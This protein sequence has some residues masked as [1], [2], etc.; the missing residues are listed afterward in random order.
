MIRDAGPIHDAPPAGPIVG[1]R[2][3]IGSFLIHLALLTTLVSYDAWLQSRQLAHAGAGGANG[4]VATTEDYAAAPSGPLPSPA[5]L[6]PGDFGVVSTNPNE[7]P[8]PPLGW[9]WA[10]TGQRI[11]ERSGLPLTLG[12]LGGH[13][14]Q[15]TLFAIVAALLTLAFRR[16]QARVRYWLWLGAS[17]K[18]LVPF[19]P[20]VVLSSQVPWSAAI[21]SLANHPIVAGIGEPLIA[22]NAGVATLLPALPLPY[23]RSASAA[24]NGYHWLGLALLVIW[25]SGFAAIVSM[26]FRAWRQLRALLAKSTPMNLSGVAIPSHIDVR[27]APGLLEPGVIGWQHPVLLMPADIA[28]HLSLPEIEAIVAHELCHVRRRDNLTAAFHMIVEALFWFHPMVWWI[29]AR[30]V[31]ERERA[32]DEH[33][34]QTVGEPRSYAQGILNVCKRYVVSP[35]PS[36]SGVSGSNVKKRIDAIL[37]NRVGEAIGPWQKVILGTALAVVLI[38][39]LGAGALYAPRFAGQVQEEMVFVPRSGGDAQRASRDAARA[40]VVLTDALDMPASDVYYALVVASR[41]RRLGPRLIASPETDCNAEAAAAGRCGLGV[42][43]S[44]EISAVGLTPAELAGTISS[45]LDRP[46]VDR[47]G[48]TGRYSFELTWTS[49]PARLSIF[50]AVRE[51]LGLTLV[52]LGVTDRVPRAA[53]EKEK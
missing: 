2:G 11:A 38:V 32:C 29:G 5:V 46:V 17:I 10:Q 36:M 9:R 30:L 27:S 8:E 16:Q 25:A 41:D 31:D 47:T 40:G 13:L 52:P 33:V 24:P 45:A 28:D 7:L 22:V 37:A 35:L 20:I 1:F 53:A 39:P 26:R 4:D 14:W 23:V 43:R 51:Q 42:V 18:F 49:K 15:S 21:R 19:A 3:F 6:R 50:T 48:L 34:L 12:T 44:G